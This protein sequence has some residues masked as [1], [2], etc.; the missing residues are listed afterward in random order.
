PVGASASEIT[1]A[2]P[3]GTST[4]LVVVPPGV[5]ARGSGTGAPVAPRYSGRPHGVHRR[6]RRGQ[7][8]QGPR[9]GPLRRLRA[10]GR[11][12]LQ[13]HGPRGPAARLPTRQGP[14][15]GARGPARGGR[16]PGRRPPARA[17]RVLRR[18]PG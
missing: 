3:T 14:P 9:R 16:R 5:A 6:A 2:Q 7:Q 15:Q 17:A 18:G 1:V 10:R 11:R 13:A 12:R 8:G 4:P